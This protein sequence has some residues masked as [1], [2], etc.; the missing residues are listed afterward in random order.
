MLKNPLSL[1]V[2]YIKAQIIE[3]TQIYLNQVSSIQEPL[4]KFNEKIN[5]LKQETNNIGENIKRV[6]EVEL[7][8]TLTTEESQ[9]NS[10]EYMSKDTSEIYKNLKTQEYIQYN[11]GNGIYL[12]CYFKNVKEELIDSIVDLWL[13]YETPQLYG[14]Q[15]LL[16]SYALKDFTGRKII[17]VYPNYSLGN[18][19]L[20]L[21]GGIKIPLGENRIYSNTAVTSEDFFR[22]TQGEIYNILNNPCYSYGI[23]FNP[24]DLFYEWQRALIYQLAILP[25]ELDIMIL[26][27]IYNEFLEFIKNEVCF[28]Q[29]GPAIIPREKALEVL[30]IQ[31]NEMRNYLECKEQ[32]TISKNSL[33]TLRN[34]YIYMP[35]I[36]EILEKHFSN[37]NNESKREYNLN[38]MKDLLTK[39][40][41]KGNYEK[42]IA[43][44]KVAKYYLETIPRNKNYWRKNKNRKRRNRFVLLQ[45]IFK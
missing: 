41:V 27:K 42:G 28:Y 23:F 8:L 38:K 26:E 16:K 43:M 15:I 5:N 40:N 13:T 32:S 19:N 17:G 37:I 18:W 24:I 34:R 25:K 7:L 9:N 2:T 31:I 3:N 6:K 30:K 12:T 4:K 45:Y 35:I 29:N 33:V 1:I 20:L 22:W 14:K 11:L 39:L 36:K 21:E 10:E 44:E